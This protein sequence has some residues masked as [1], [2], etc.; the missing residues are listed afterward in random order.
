MAHGKKL[1]SYPDNT[2]LCV[3]NVYVTVLVAFDALAIQ[4]L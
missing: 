1:Y 3:F 4:D 2:G